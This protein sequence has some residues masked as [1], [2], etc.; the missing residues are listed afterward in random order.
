MKCPFCGHP[1]TQVVDSRVSDEGES[2]KRRRRNTLMA[3]QKKI[4]ARAQKGR[5]GSEVAV[6]IDTFRPLKVSDAAR[7]ISAEDYAWSW[8]TPRP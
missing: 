4:V 7:S 6:M 5:I 2:V 8:P 3:R 1:D